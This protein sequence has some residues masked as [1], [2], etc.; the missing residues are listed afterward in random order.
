MAEGLCFN[1]ESLHRAMLA[2]EAKELGTPQAEQ[3]SL[4]DSVG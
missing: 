3:L 1:E 4:F 2:L